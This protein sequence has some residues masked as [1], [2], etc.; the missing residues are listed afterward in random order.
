MRSHPGMNNSPVSAT[1]VKPA[2]R[3]MAVNVARV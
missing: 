3:S 2:S 1:I